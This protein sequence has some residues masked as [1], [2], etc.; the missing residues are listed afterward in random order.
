MRM[1]ERRPPC[2]SAGRFPVA[3]TMDDG[4]ED[5][6]DKGS[7]MRDR[8]EGASDRAGKYSTPASSKAT[9][10]AGLGECDGSGEG[11]RG[12]RDDEDN[13]PGCK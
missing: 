8:V 13:A 9:G 2:S 12:C 11:L 1:L 4:R 7:E 6:R 3:L 5:G 10:V